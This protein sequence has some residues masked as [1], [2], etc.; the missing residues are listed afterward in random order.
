MHHGE[1]ATATSMVSGIEVALYDFGT[2]LVQIYDSRYRKYVPLDCRYSGT[3]RERFIQPYDTTCVC[4]IKEKF[5]QLNASCDA[6][7][8]SPRAIRPKQEQHSVKAL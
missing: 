2:F 3:R 4:Y 8:L 5:P 6:C 1:E 7:S